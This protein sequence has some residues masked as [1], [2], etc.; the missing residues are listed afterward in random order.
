MSDKCTLFYG[1][2]NETRHLHDN[3]PLFEFVALFLGHFLPLVHWFIPNIQ[4]PSDGVLGVVA[5]FNPHQG[6]W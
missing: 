5:F 3:A 2:K 1:S 4:P 6:Q